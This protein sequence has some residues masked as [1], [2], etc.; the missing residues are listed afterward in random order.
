MVFKIDAILM[1]FKNRQ[2]MVF[3][4]GHYNNGL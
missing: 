3:K 2:L 1:V 4:N